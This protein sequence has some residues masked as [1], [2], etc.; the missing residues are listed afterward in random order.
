[1]MRQAGGKREACW[2][3]HH[4]RDRVGKSHRLG[5]YTRLG[6][7]LQCRHRLHLSTA[8]TSRNIIFRAVSRRVAVT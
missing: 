4:R 3:Q 7:V 8:F 2:G 5:V 1:M 6:P